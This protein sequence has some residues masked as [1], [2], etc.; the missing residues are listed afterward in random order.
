MNGRFFRNFSVGL[1][2]VR[3]LIPIA[4]WVLAGQAAPGEDALR[5]DFHLWIDY[6][7]IT[8]LPPQDAEGIE[9]PQTPPIEHAID[10]HDADK[11]TAQPA[12]LGNYTPH[13]QV[14]ST[15]SGLQFLV[16]D[17]MMGTKWSRSLEEPIVGVQYVAMRYRA[18]NLRSWGDYV[19]YA[20]CAESATRNSTCCARANSRPM[21]SGMWPSPA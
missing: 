1:S 8:A 17:G 9:R 11:W 13:H 19:L 18:R 14:A 5:G 4:V 16:D 15:P 2:A 10:L 12:W 21:V 6:L 3:L 7:A 20:A